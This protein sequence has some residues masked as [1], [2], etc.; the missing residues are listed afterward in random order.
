[1]LHRGLSPRVSESLHVSKD[2]IAL[3]CRLSCRNSLTFVKTDVN[4]LSSNRGVGH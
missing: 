3:A 1:M 4:E 2:T